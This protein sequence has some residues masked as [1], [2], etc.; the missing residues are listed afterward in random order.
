MVAAEPMHYA[1][2]VVAEE[3]PRPPDQPLDHRPVAAAGQEDSAE[4]ATEAAEPAEQVAGEQAT[5]GEVTEEQVAEPA[6]EQAGEEQAT[7]EQVAEPAEE[8]SVEPAAEEPTAA[9]CRV[10][11]QHV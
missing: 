7:E 1:A 10:A 4:G 9:L 2:A 11:S 3:Q 5:E 8:Q 6:E